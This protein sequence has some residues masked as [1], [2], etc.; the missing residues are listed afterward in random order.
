[1]NISYNFE[2]VENLLKNIERRKKIRK[3]MKQDKK[4]IIIK[5]Y[6]KK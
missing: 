5:L 3:I 2:D 6:F 4:N 1:M